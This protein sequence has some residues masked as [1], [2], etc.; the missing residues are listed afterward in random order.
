MYRVEKYFKFRNFLG[1]M[2][3]VL[4][5]KYSKVKNTLLCA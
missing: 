2:D 5:E 1:V 4:K 3:M